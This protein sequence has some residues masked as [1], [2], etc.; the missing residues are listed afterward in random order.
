MDATQERQPQIGD[1]VIYVNDIREERAAT[2]DDIWYRRRVDLA[3]EGAPRVTAVYY[4][5]AGGPF[6][7]HWPAKA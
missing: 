5:P 2:I 7:W 4:D 3:F 6:T 1:A